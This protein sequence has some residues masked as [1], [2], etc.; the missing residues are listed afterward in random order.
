MT[1]VC[2]TGRGLCVFDPDSGSAG[3]SA[4][5]TAGGTSG[6][7]AGGMAGGTSG[8]MAGGMAGGTSGGM[9]G[10]TAGGTAGGGSLLFCDAGCAV[11]ELCEATTTTAACVSGALV[12]TQPID[13]GV[14]AAGS[15]VPVE[16]TLT[17]RDGGS[18]PMPPPI[19]VA[20]S[21]GPSTQLASGAPEFINGGDA[22]F[23]TISFGWDG[24]PAARRNVEFQG[25]SIQCPS[26]QRCVPTSG[27]GRCE[28]YDWE[29]AF[30]MPVAP[31]AFVAGPLQA[32]VPVEVSV[33]A[34]GGAPLP[35]SVPLFIDG[36]VRLLMPLTMAG[37]FGGMVTLSSA[38]VGPAE[39]PKGLVAG[40]PDAGVATLSATRSVE[41][42]TTGPSFTV[43]PPA[44]PTYT[45]S[46]P[47]LLVDPA[48]PMAVKKD[49]VVVLRVTSPASDVNAGAVVLTVQTAGGQTW[50]A[51]VGVPCGAAPFC[52]D[53]SMALGPQPMNAFTDTV[54]V[55][56][57]GADLVGN[58]GTG[59]LQTPMTVTRWKWARRVTT[60]EVRASLAVGNDGGVFVA[61]RGTTGG[62]FVVT[63]QGASTSLVTSAPIDASPA[64]GRNAS[65][66]DVV[67]YMD[68]TSGLRAVSATNGCGTGNPANLGSLAVLNDG[69][70][71]VRAVGVV[72]DGASTS[73]QAAGPGSCVA[74]GAAAVPGMAYPGNI[75]TDG[76]S[77]WYPSANGQIQR[78]GTTLMSLTALSG[79]GAGTIYGLSLFGTRLAGGGGGA[80]VGRIFVA[81]NDGAMIVGENPLLHV[82][83]VAVGRSGANDVLFAL[84][85]TG[86]EQAELKRFSSASGVTTGTA[87]LPLGFQFNFPASSIPGGTTPV[88]GA[89]GLV[90]AVANNG[91]VAAVDQS[92]MAVRW[93]RILTGLATPGQVQASATLD[94][95]RDKPSSGTGVYY[96]ATSTGWLVGYIVDSPGLDPTAPWPKYQHDA[97][98][99][100]NLGVST[101]CP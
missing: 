46:G 53:Y 84:M 96:F 11:W 17:L 29:V 61:A 4:G 20:A 71:T 2:D 78:T 56:V 83:G 91:N 32:S 50:D 59:A 39:G 87:P 13:G 5:G 22:G 92:T 77:V 81:N 89:N 38:L 51:G 88:L 70:A 35:V 45:N 26:F 57:A 75:V 74:I 8:G 100:G 23:G 16:A 82:S 68:Q 30:V 54:N 97:R 52:R 49:E 28:T 86:A 12:V 76:T 44:L 40:W 47:L 33:A 7:A 55:S 95:N 90:Y 60:E 36:G 66:A 3:G 93:T 101:A 64:I 6:G 85:Q 37:R 65:G 25:C 24:G 19:P 72:W 62:L 48:A 73:L 94:C 99:T 98:N 31:P 34:R 18:F 43:Q 42:D 27:G 15:P 9:A 63:P 58:P 41:W 67:F 79:F 14:Y 1:G 80:G 21:W 69:T 10:G